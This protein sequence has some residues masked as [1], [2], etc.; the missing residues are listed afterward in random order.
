MKKFVL[1][2]AVF[3]L[4]MSIVSPISA[5][6][7]NSEKNFLFSVNEKVE[8]LNQSIEGEVFNKGNKYFFN[9]SKVPQSFTNLSTKFY[10]VDGE[11]VV[12]GKAV[13][14]NDDRSYVFS[15]EDKVIHTVYNGKEYYFGPL[16]SDFIYKGEQQTAII[17]LFY[18]KTDDLLTVSTTLGKMN[19]DKGV[20]LLYFGD[21]MNNQWDIL[22]KSQENKRNQLESK[23]PTIIENETEFSIQ[24]T[25]DDYL[26]AHRVRDKVYAVTTTDGTKSYSTPNLDWLALVDVYVQDAKSRSLSSVSD[27]QANT[28][29]IVNNNNVKAATGASAAQVFYV[30]A[31]L[32]F[33]GDVVNGCMHETLNWK[34]I[35]KNAIKQFPISLPGKFGTVTT[36]LNGAIDILNEVLDSGDP[37][38]SSC[39]GKVVGHTWRESVDYAFSDAMDW[40][41]SGDPPSIQEGD[42]IGFDGSIDIQGGGA[43]S[44]QSYV[45]SYHYI[46][47]V[48]DQ[49]LIAYV[50]ATEDPITRVYFTN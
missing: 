50:Y 25:A 46:E 27:A 42:Q 37:L 38:K 22:R 18:N 16:H 23:D 35:P 5:N 24:N 10:E 30:N 41:G 26:W 28:N 39:G 9:V 40:T 48:I 21:R 4:F 11:Y 33:T 12:K 17:G 49:G 43:P 15:F 14:H 1:I 45:E 3:S 29:I 6:T 32:K 7:Q 34:P 36:Y 47:W 20:G 8:Y 19:G 2:I 44:G 13:I 31:R